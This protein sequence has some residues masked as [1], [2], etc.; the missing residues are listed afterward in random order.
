MEA[1]GQE[2]EEEK[3][4][5]EEAW[6]ACFVGQ[7]VEGEPTLGTRNHMTTNVFR[8]RRCGMMNASKQDSNRAYPCGFSELLIKFK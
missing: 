5:E 7:A 4:E 8:R 2:L 6:A 1:A 3:E